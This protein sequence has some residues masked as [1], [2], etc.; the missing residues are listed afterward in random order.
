MV[1]VT[2]DPTVIDN[3]GGGVGLIIGDGQG[4]GR[5]AV[6]GGGAGDAAEYLSR[7]K[8]AGKVPVVT[9]QR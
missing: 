9:A 7:V 4:E 2:P 3:R 5:G 6:G 8:P 1:M